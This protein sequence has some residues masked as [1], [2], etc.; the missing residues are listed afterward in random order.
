MFG[1]WNLPSLLFIF[2]SLLILLLISSVNFYLLSSLSFRLALGCHYPIHMQPSTPSFSRP[3][4]PYPAGESG[5]PNPMGS[6]GGGAAADS[7][8]ASQA[9]VPRPSSSSTRSQPSRS[10]V[11]SRVSVNS[12]THPFNL[13][14]VLLIFGSLS[15]LAR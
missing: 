15:P 1:F 6:G 12:S 3:Q 5:Q 13:R 8:M 9:S 7:A 2:S 4:R 14:G 11:V 10:V